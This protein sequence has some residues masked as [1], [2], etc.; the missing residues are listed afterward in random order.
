MGKALKEL[1]SQFR[2]KETAKEEK[3][4]KKMSPSAYAKGERMEGEKTVK[5][6][7]RK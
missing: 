7:G 6:V 5:K 1:L 2:G 4:E 3:K